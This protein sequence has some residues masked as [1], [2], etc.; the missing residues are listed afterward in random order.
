[1]RLPDR[2][3][4]WHLYAVEL[5]PT[6]GQPTRAAVF[7]ALRAAQIGV[8]VH[9]IPIHTQPYYRALGFRRGDFPQAE[10]YYAHAISLPL[11]P[12]LSDAD[13]D[14]VV[15]VLRAALGTAGWAPLTIE[16]AE[17]TA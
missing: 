11:Y 7:A 14:R 10:H 6:P 8:N 9:Y 4:A 16:T 17:V 1:V 3:S 13:Q 12:E 5:I 2:S 15:A